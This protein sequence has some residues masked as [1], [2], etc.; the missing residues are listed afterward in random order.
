MDLGEACR[1]K[2]FQSQITSGLLLNVMS[3]AKTRQK[4]AKKRSLLGVN[5]HFEPI[6]TP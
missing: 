1:A 6:L 2:V 5:E 3:V 4:L